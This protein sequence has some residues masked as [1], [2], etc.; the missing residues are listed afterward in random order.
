MGETVRKL[1][2]VLMDRA[3][4]SSVLFSHSVMADSCDPWTTAHQASLSIAN[5][6]GLLKLMSIKLVMS[7]NHLISVFSFSSCLQ[8]FPAS[9]YFQ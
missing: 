5:S 7:S 4:I 2:L 1:G 6:Q 8:S 9:G 3:M